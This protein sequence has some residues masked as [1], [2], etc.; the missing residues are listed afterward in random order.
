MSK[1]NLLGALAM[2]LGLN[3]GS[4]N[5]FHCTCWYYQGG[6]DWKCLGRVDPFGGDFIAC[7][8][9]CNHYITGGSNW[10]LIDDAALQRCQD[11]KA[12][13]LGAW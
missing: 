10:P 9:A 11:Q 8:N 13:T 12:P 6:T 2:T 5:A 7:R 3:F 4:A 1:K